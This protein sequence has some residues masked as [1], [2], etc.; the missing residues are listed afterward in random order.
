LGGQSVAAFAFI[1]TTARFVLQSAGLRVWRRRARLARH[2]SASRARSP[3]GIG[4]QLS[5]TVHDAAAMKGARRFAF[6]FGTT[7]AKS[8]DRRLQDDDATETEPKEERHRS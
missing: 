2:F 6:A 7:L 8:V 3:S 5:E 4:Q 1:A